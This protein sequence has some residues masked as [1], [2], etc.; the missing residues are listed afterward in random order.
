MP[1]GG[2]RDGAGRKD[3][4]GALVRLEIGARCFALFRAARP[5]TNEH[6]DA[7]SELDNLFDHLHSI[8]VADR[9]EWKRSEDADGLFYDI[10]TERSE[11]L[12]TL[13]DPDP[14]PGM[15][16]QHKRPYAVWD[17]IFSSVSDEFTM[18]L[19]V[20]VTPRTVRQCRDKYRKDLKISQRV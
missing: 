2:R 7:W 15:K 10:E 9:A 18:Q 6:D 5:S 16:R 14:A 4:L 13:V 3:K 20:T 1:R 17:G 12:N 8:P 19:G 11:I